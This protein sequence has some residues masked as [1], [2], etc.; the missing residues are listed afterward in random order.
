MGT[1]SKSRSANEAGMSRRQN[2]ECEGGSPARPSSF[3]ELGPLADRL[4]DESQRMANV[5]AAL[6]NPARIEI[7]R[8]IARH[9]HCGCKDVTSRMSLAQSTVS[10][11]LKVLC[12]AGLIELQSVPPRSLYSIN[13]R[14]IEELSER[15][16]DF[17]HSCCGR[18]C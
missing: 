13:E 3:E 14:L 6:A 11:H 1:A 18:N 17:L 5:F 9:R 7:L 2:L 8:H 12:E 15:T 4:D 10:Q 16:R